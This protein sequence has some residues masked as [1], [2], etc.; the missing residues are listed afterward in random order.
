MKNRKFTFEKLI[1]SDKNRIKINNSLKNLAATILL[2]ILLMIFFVVPTQTYSQEQTISFQHEIYNPFFRPTI[3]T[4]TDDNANIDGSLPDTIT[5]SVTSTSDP[6]GISL[7]L[8][9]TGDNTGVFQNTDLI[10]TDGNYLFSLDDLITVVLN[11][12]GFNFD[13]NTIE[14]L[15]DP[16]IVLS[17]SDEDGIIIFLTETQK[18]SGI[19]EGNFSFNS[20]IT[21]PESFSLLAKPGDVIS[22]LYPCDPKQISIGLMVPNS[23]P[24][25]GVILAPVGD[26]VTV[27]YGE[28]SDTA[29]PQNTIGSGGSSGGLVINRVVLDVLAGGNSGG[30]FEPPLLTIPKLNLSNLPLVGDLLNFILN[31]D[32]FTP[33]APLDDPA[34]DYPASINGNGYLLTQ[35]AN[36]I[37]TY[38]GTTGEPISFKMNLSDATGVEHIGLYTNLRGDAREVQDS[39]TFIIYNEAKPLEITDPHGFFSNVNFTESEYNGKYIAD[40]N[41]TFAKPMDTSDVIIRTWDELRNSGDIKIFDAIKIEGEPIVNPDTNSLIAPESSSITIPYYKLP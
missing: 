7:E 3:I 9:E 14:S 16:M 23:D 39:D 22:A 6:H 12:P 27:T 24:T 36:T 2:F 28:I 11:C 18:D 25:V 32:A 20:E 30:D 17:S 21:N 1:M 35:F 10:F 13:S 4:V 29:F 34:I 41:M 31:A 37:Q 38:K 26:T 33:I 8:I 19:F 40:F 15:E 5:V